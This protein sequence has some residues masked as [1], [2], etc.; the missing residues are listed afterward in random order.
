MTDEN[1][2]KMRPIKFRAWNKKLKRMY[3]SIEPYI[4]NL[5]ADKGHPDCGGHK[6]QG[7]LEEMY[8][9]K[10]PI[11]QYTGLKDKNGKE[12]YEGD[13][14]HRICKSK[15]C[16]KTQYDWQGIVVWRENGFW[17]QDDDDGIIGFANSE[18][19]EIEVIGN[20]YENPGGNK[21]EAKKFK[22]TVQDIIDKD[23]ECPLP[24]DII[25]NRMGINLC[26]VDSVEWTRQTDNQLID[27]KINFI[28]SI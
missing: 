25:P 11:M 3:Y 9:T 23:L 7:S 28:P 16:G 6:P 19:E 1:D 8:K 15:C 22:E 13:I 18:L 17:F 26:S 14:L 4:T 5:R 20:I 12:I 10:C 24:L 21:M 2:V 27:L